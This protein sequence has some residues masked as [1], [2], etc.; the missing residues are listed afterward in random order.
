MDPEANNPQVDFSLQEMPPPSPPSHELGQTFPTELIY[1]IISWVLSNSIHSI[2]LSKGDVNWEMDVMNILC[3]VSPSFGAI[4]I[5]IAAKAFAIEV[6]SDD[7]ID[8]EEER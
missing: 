8:E 2:C 4:A 1:G 6:E 5:E 3:D 7:D